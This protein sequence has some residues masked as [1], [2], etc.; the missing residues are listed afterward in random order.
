V[1][2]PRPLA[3]RLARVLGGLLAVVGLLLAL[4]AAHERISA[5]RDAARFPPPGVLVDIGG[6]RLHLRCLGEGAPT[7]LFEA[8]GTNGST[9]YAGIQE[10]LAARTRTCAYDRAGMGWSDPSPRPLD[11]GALVADLEALLTRADVAGPY[12]V[13]AGSAGGLTAELFARRH[14]DDLAGLVLLDALHGDM[15]DRFPDGARRLARD[16]SLARALAHVGL[17]RLIDPYDLR[18][19]PDAERERAIALKYHAGT[20]DAVTSLI[21][22]RETTAAQIR[23]APPLR[24]DLPL[25]VVTHDPSRGGE[26]PMSEADWREAQERFAARSVSGRLVV[27]ERSGHHP[28]RDRPDLVLAILE[29]VLDEATAR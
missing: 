16:A 29:E 11:A 7:V 8:G 2:A 26:V 3:R 27:A 17:L 18:A 14:P 13:V 1:P 6:R 21:G 23:S 4:G 12:V 5:R 15:I 20:W 10:P 25:V 9:V 22:A 28:E 19:L 24:S